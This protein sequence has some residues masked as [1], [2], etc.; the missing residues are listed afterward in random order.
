MATVNN[1]QGEL[2]KPTYIG[3]HGNKWATAWN[4][5]SN[6]TGKINGTS[7]GTGDVVRIGVLPSGL[8][9]YPAQFTAMFSDAFTA[10]ATWKF[11]FQFV[12][13]TA[14]QGG[15]AQD[16]QYFLTATTGSQAIQRGN[17][18]ASA[19]VT[20]P[21]D[22]YLIGTLAGAALTDAGIVDIVVEGEFTGTK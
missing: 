16:D 7:V 6:S 17:N 11:G 1:V 22:A 10:N 18:A 20:L 5:Q 8:K 19:V 3:P 12:N 2:A 4:M 21:S 13:G 9:M 15:V 14:T